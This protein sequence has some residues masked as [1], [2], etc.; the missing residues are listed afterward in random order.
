MK[1][2]SLQFDQC[3]RFYNHEIFIKL[4]LPILLVLVKHQQKSAKY[5]DLRLLT[6]ICIIQIYA[7]LM[8]LQIFKCGNF[9]GSP[10]K[11]FRFS[12]FTKVCQ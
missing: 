3:F 10:G 8:V 9:F 4:N 12:V 1:G 6:E 11:D 7:V 5:F 2:E